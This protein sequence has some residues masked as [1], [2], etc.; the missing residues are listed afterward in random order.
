MTVIPLQ[1][2]SNGNCVYVESGLTG[3]LFDAGISGIKAEQRLAR[4]GRDIRQIQAVIVS[5][6]HIDHIS[7]AGIFQRKYG[8]PLYVTKATLAKASKWNRIGRLSDINYF[9][10]GQTIYCANLSIETIP[11]PH[12]GI[13]SVAFIVEDNDRRL[14]ILTDLGHVFEGLP[15][16][17]RSLDALLLES[18]YDPTLLDSGPYPPALKRRIKGEGGH[19]SNFESAEL[20][21]SAATSRLKWVCL[22]HLSEQNNTP[23]I[24][25]E[26]HTKIIP[27]EIELFTASRFQAVKLPHL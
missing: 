3:V 11:T 23:S 24:A 22:A 2:G 7:C 20:L 19:I 1:S 6:E 21:R 10:P 9:E 25:V 16:M 8:L 13:E 27:T 18:N 14:G 12:D 4:F 17:I 26:T 5:H 15:E